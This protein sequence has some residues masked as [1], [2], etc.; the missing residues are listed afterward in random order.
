VKTSETTLAIFLLF[1]SIT[2][3]NTHSCWIS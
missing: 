3:W 2:G 1:A